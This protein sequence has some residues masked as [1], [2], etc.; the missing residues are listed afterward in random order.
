MANYH[1]LILCDKHT[2]MLTIVV[3]S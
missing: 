1:K 2:L 3:N